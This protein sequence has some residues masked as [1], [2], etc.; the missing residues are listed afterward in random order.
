M[1][2]HEINHPA[3]KGAPMT[4]HGTPFKEVTERF[5]H[6]GTNCQWIGWDN[7]HRK[8]SIFPMKRKGVSSVSFS[9]SHFC[10]GKIPIH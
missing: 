2:F 1:D 4:I 7:L 10:G 8:P 9:I 6:H 5:G 3:I